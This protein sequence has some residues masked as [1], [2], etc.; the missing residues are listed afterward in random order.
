M[1]S[2]CKKQRDLQYN[3]ITADQLILEW[4]TTHTSFNDLWEIEMEAIETI[5]WSSNGGSSPPETIGTKMQRLTAGFEHIIQ[6][7][8]MLLAEQRWKDRQQST[9][10]YK[11]FSGGNTWHEA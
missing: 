8:T 6:P 1:A 5:S 4:D 11:F 7:D 3:M 10:P 2:H 9:N